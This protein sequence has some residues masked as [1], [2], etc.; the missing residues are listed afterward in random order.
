MVN[1]NIVLSDGSYIDIL[2]ISQIPK[3]EKIK[4]VLIKK[5]TAK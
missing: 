1:V 5:A 3:E 4:E 2:T